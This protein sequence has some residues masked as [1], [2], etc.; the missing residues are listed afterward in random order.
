MKEIRLHAVLTVIVL[1]AVFAFGVSTF[2]AFTIWSYHR[3]LL[4]TRVNT[5]IKMKIERRS[6]WLTDS[7]RSAC[8]TRWGTGDAW[9][10][11]LIESWW[12]WGNTTVIEEYHGLWATGA[13]CWC[14]WTS[15][16]GRLAACTNLLNWVGVK[17]DSKT[18]RNTRWRWWVVKIKTCL[19]W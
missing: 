5:I 6:T 16:T 7:W 13:C 11:L 12:T 14:G 2:L 15:N 10:G 4:W 8:G 18:V 3:V 9:W 1:C 17:I 19:T